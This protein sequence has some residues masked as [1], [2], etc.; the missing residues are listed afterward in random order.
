M[1]SDKYPVLS[2]AEYLPSVQLVEFAK[3]IQAGSG[4]VDT[5]HYLLIILGWLVLAVF[6]TIAVYR[7]KEL[8]D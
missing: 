2:F 4:L 8:D 6:L 1:M 5:W 3:D 7:K